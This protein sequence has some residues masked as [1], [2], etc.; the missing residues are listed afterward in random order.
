M[1]IENFVEAFDSHCGS[2]RG[3]CECGKVYYNSNGGWD[4][5]KDELKELRANNA[6][7]LEYSVSFLRFEGREYVQCCNCW[8][9]RA[10]QIMNFLDGHRN[11][12]A[13]YFELEKERCLKE[14]QNMPVIL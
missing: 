7:D 4:W 9:P 5:E 6:I 10:K 14:V 12:I 8:I 2:C 13:K 11:A 3:Q 1:N